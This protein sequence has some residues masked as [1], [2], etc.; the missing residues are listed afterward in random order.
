MEDGSTKV[1]KDVCT[2]VEQAITTSNIFILV[3]IHFFETHVIYK[4]LNTELTII[5]HYCTGCDDILIV[6]M[7]HHVYMIGSC[8][9]W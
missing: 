7:S 2:P 9:K 4:C 5:T 1:V 3:L 8:S 6:L